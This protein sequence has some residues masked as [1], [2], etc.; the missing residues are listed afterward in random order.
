MSGGVHRREGATELG[1]I[2]PIKRI[3][4]VLP[5]EEPTKDPTPPTPAE[6]E[7]D[8]IEPERVPHE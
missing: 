6:P 7:R 1:D 3:I 2:G 8:P 4:E 5:A